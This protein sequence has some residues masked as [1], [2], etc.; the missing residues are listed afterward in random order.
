V[1]VAGWSKHIDVIVQSFQSGKIAEGL[2]EAIGRIGE[3]LAAHFPPRPDD[4]N[5]LPNEVVVTQR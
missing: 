5:E 3:D 1:G 2:V 4:T